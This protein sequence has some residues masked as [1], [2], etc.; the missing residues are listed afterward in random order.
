MS[1]EKLC[2][3]IRYTCI[4]TVMSSKIFG[5]ER[6]TEPFNC[7]ITKWNQLVSYTFL[8]S[9]TQK[10]TIGWLTHAFFIVEL[11]KKF[12]NNVFSNSAVVWSEKWPNSTGFTLRQ[13]QLSKRF[14]WHRVQVLDVEQISLAPG[15]DIKHNQMSWPSNVATNHPV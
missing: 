1:C 11:L 15:L 13:A 5:L 2:S 8:R 14:A 9:L 7:Q 12:S 4:Y 10:R 6:L 3:N